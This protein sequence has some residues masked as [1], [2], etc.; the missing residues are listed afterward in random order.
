MLLILVSGFGNKNNMVRGGD[1]KNRLVRFLIVFFALFTTHSGYAQP[2]DNDQVEDAKQRFNRA[3]QYYQEGNYQAALS[4]FKKAYQVAPKYQVLYNIGTVQDVLRDYAGAI[5]SFEQYLQQGA[6]EI[7]LSR[8]EEVQREIEKLRLRVAT[9]SLVTY[10]PGAQILVD[11][12][13]V[14]SSTPSRFLVSAGKRRITVQKNGFRSAT[15]LIDAAGSETLA[16]NISLERFDDAPVAIVSASNSSA[17]QPPPPVAKEPTAFRSDD[18]PRHHT[19]SSNAALWAGWATTG[20]LL[21]GT[22]V[23][24]GLALGAKADRDAQRES[25]GADNSSIRAANDRARTFALVSDVLAGATVVAAGA[26]L[27]FTLYRD[28]KDKNKSVQL[29]ASASTLMLTGQY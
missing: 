14:N 27:Y 25:L 7:P 26:S 13:L 24:G 3:I 28:S 6:G 16:V 12:E 9:I 11:D 23:M 2:I 21:T 29:N 4:E 20:A 15:R 19:K 5:A 10:P 1:P 22:I 17:P 8:K 18:E